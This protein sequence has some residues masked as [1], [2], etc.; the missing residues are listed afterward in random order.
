MT[1][2]TVIGVVAGTILFWAGMAMFFI[3]VKK[4]KSSKFKKEKSKSRS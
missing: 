4:D 3:G 2:I 1:D